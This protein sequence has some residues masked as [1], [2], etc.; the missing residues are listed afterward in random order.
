MYQSRSGSDDW[1]TPIAVLITAMMLIAMISINADFA[2]ADDRARPKLRETQSAR[3]HTATQEPGL[4]GTVVARPPK[5]DIADRIATLTAVATALDEVADGATYVW[6][7]RTGRLSGLFKPI[8]SYTD[9]SGRICRVIQL[10]LT[11][12]H[13]TESRVGRA[14]HDRDGGWSL[15]AAQSAGHW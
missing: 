10:T 4:R 2:I 15:G 9:D 11:A 6:Y 3:S 1:S 8:R 7:R 5:F 12:R 14:C 13:M